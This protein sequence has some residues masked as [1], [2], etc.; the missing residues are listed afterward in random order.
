MGGGG[1]FGATLQIVTAFR[2]PCT[3]LGLKVLNLDCSGIADPS[4]KLQSRLFLKSLRMLEVQEIEQTDTWDGMFEQV[5]L[6]SFESKHDLCKKAVVGPKGLSSVS[7]W[8][9]FKLVVLS[10]KTTTT[11]SKNIPTIKGEFLFLQPIQYS[12]R[13]ILTESGIFTLFSSELIAAVTMIGAIYI[14]TKGPVMAGVF[15]TLVNVTLT[16][17]F[18]KT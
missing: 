14:L 16:A 2:C 12:S 4:K 3:D 9:F 5:F 6:F 17:F 8:C 11:T 15:S 13:H 18:P 1:K 10:Q 7:A